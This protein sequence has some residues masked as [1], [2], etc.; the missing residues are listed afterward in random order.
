MTTPYF[1]CGLG[2][3][4]LRV[5]RTDNRL[6]REALIARSTV[7]EGVQQKLERAVAVAQDLS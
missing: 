6:F 1:F 2:E 3:L 4:E 5:P 7:L